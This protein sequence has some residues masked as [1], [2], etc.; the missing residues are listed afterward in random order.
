MTSRFIRT[1][2]GTRYS[3][4]TGL[5]VRTRRSAGY[6]LRKAEHYGRLAKDSLALGGKLLGK[7]YRQLSREFKDKWRR[8]H[9]GRTR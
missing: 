2:G 7:H 4:K 1:P 9:H 6:Y 3:K 8:A 5:P